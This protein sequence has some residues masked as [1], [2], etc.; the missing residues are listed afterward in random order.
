MWYFRQNSFEDIRTIHDW[1]AHRKEMAKT[2]EGRVV[3]GL[4]DCD[5]NEPL[6]LSNTVYQSIAELKKSQYT[7]N[8]IEFKTGERFGV[9]IDKNQDPTKI[10]VDYTFNSE[11][12]EFIRED[13]IKTFEC[14]YGMKIG[15]HDRYIKTIRLYKYV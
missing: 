15:F 7:V 11:S 6:D 3:I 9:I 14:I 12:I 4:L 13:E 8:L 10:F 5:K 2:P 1:I